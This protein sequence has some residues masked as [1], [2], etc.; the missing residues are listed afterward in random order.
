VNY[1]TIGKK[2]KKKKEGYCGLVG[3]QEAGFNE[4]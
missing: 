1:A 2:I 3:L 4:K